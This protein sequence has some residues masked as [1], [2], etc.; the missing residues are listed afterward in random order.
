MAK[1]KK[2]ANYPNEDAPE[3]T[4]SDFYAEPLQRRRN[5]NDVELLTPEQ[6]KAKDQKEDSEALRYGR[7]LNSHVRD[8]LEKSGREETGERNKDIELPDEG[9]SIK[10]EITPK[11]KK[12]IASY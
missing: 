2:D 6:R 7:P 5:F 8:I 4:I 10:I 1:K 12:S 3:H 11:R 9:P